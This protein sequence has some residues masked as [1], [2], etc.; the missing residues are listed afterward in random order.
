G[1]LLPRACSNASEPR[2]VR[3]RRP[4]WRPLRQDLA[5]ICRRAVEHVAVDWLVDAGHVA[6]GGEL[7]E[8]PGPVAVDLMRLGGDPA[9]PEIISRQ[10]PPEHAPME[11][12]VGIDD[13]PL[14]GMG[15]HDLEHNLDL[16][17]C[18]FRRDTL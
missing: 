8:Q 9:Q 10:L 17:E 2:S 11:G 1:R 13:R 6:G 16:L 3:A 12:N 15:F 7:P 5:P 14:A 18:E 4:L